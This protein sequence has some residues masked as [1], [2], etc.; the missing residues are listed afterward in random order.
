MFDQDRER[1]GADVGRSAGHD[2][3]LQEH[4]RQLRRR[5]HH[6]AERLQQPAELLPPVRHTGS[7]GG[8][9]V[10]CVTVGSRGGPQVQCVT[11]G[12]RGGVFTFMFFI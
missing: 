2:D 5:T 7:N 9:Q 12:S 4:V 1:H 3:D 10:Q 6:Q 8:P 11:V